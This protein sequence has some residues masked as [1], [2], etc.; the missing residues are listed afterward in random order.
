MTINKFSGKY[1]FL[2]NFFPVK[3]EFEGSIYPTVE[4]AYQAAKT[5][6]VTTREEIRNAPTPGAAKLIGKRI[7]SLREDWEQ[8]KQDVMIDLCIQ[9]FNK[10]P[11]RTKLLQTGDA[12]LIEGNTWGDVYWGMCNGIGENH[13]GKILMSIRMILKNG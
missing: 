1:K 10:E 4:H 11:Y 5:F 9:K 2:S 6:H 7:Q 8:V 13:L 3:V 12:R